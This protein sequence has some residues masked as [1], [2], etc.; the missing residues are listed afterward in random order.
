MPRIPYPDETKLSAEMRAHLGE[1]PANVT[2]MMAAASEPVF[3]GVSAIGSAFI[4]GSSLPDKLREIAILRAGYVCGSR[5]E[6]FQHE[7][8]G[9]Y[10][11]LTDAQIDA[12]REGNAASPALDEVESAVLAFA[13]DVIQNVRASDET[14]AAVR[15]HLSDAHVIDLI[16]VTGAYLMISRFLETTGVELDEEPIDWDEFT[17][18]QGG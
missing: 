12:V 18:A 13:D 11:G 6:T 3:K 10:V 1:I 9:R 5:Y 16:L 7:A 14:L 17:K 2:R 4:S 8:L 15:K